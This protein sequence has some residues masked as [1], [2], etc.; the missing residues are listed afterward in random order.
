MKIETLNYIIQGF[1]VAS[2]DVTR[3]HITHVKVSGHGESVEICATDGH[4]L[5]CVTVKDEELAPLLKRP[6]FFNRDDLPGLKAIA[7]N[8]KHGVPV[9][10]AGGKVVFGQGLTVTSS[11]VD[12][13]PE[14]EQLWPKSIDDRFS[15]SL[16]AEYLLA[17][18]KAMQEGSRQKLNVRL[19]F[20]GKL[21]PIIVGLGEHEGLLMPVRL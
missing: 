8:W 10:E 13:Y 11:L 2:R 6:Q 4:M 18:A 20:K 9:A 21:D 17:M 3:Y 19:S 16:N 1:N 5:T 14:L 7:K 12:A 15:V